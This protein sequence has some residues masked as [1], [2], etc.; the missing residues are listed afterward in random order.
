MK[1]L[2]TGGTGFV[3]SEVVRRLR[4]AGHAARLLVRDPVSPRVRELVPHFTTELLTGDV[5]DAP[6]LGQALAGCDAVIHL[7]GIIGEVGRSTFENIHTRGTENVVG[8]AK[9]A[10]VRRLVHMSALGTRPGARSRYHQSKWAAEEVVRQSGLDWTIFRPS[11]IYGPGDQFVNLFARMARFSPVLP[12]M[13]SG[14]T[15]FQPI[16]VGDVAACFVKAL[17]EPRAIGQTYELC[18][19]ETF[20]L[21]ELLREILVVT[22]SHRWIVRLPLGVARLQAALLE[23]VFPRLL[24]QAPPLNRDQ[25]IMLEEDNVGDPRPAM[26]LFGFRPVPFAEGIAKYLKFERLPRARPS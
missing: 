13:G 1:V 21:L 25:L 2:V 4:D 5:L 23:F 8:A 14:R 22:G 19:L 24:G 16:T 10:G 26:E 17:T 15:K 18:G 7:V 9:L 3:G 20:T 11:L 6:S 12:V